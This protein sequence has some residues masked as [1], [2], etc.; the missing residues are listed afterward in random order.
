[1]FKIDLCFGTYRRV[2]LGFPSGAQYVDSGAG[3]P[4]LGVYDNFIVG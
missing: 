2:L 3:V 1:M 4:K